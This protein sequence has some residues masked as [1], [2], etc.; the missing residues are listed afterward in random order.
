MH[1]CMLSDAFRHIAC[2]G[3]N[4]RSKLRSLVNHLADFFFV[5]PSYSYAYVY[6]IYGYGAH[7]KL[8]E[9]CE[10]AVRLVFE[11]SHVIAGNRDTC[12]A[13]ETVEMALQSAMD[14]AMVVIL[15]F[16]TFFFFV[17]FSPIRF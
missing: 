3:I 8:E 6:S 17:F 7:F 12:A 15:S 5:V 11:I 14:C 9:D 13:M 16:L 2:L 1:A 10:D 4:R